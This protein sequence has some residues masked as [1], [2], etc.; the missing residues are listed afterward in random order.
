MQAWIYAVETSFA[1]LGCLLEKYNVVE[2]DKQAEGG[3]YVVQQGFGWT[4]G[5]TSRF[6]RLLSLENA[7]TLT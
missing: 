7:S 4:N 5:V 1:H 2:P 6:Y 3:E